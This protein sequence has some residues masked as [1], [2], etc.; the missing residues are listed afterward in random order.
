MP[1]WRCSA[2]T[3]TRPDN[4][5]RRSTALPAPP[6]AFRVDTGL[7]ESELRLWLGEP[8][9]AFDQLHALLVQTAGAAPPSWSGPL[10]IL[11]IRACADLAEQARADRNADELAAAQTHA[12][13]LSALHQQ[14]TEDPF[15]PG[16]RRLTAHADGLMWQAEWS[17]LRS[18]SDPRLWERAASAWDARTRPHR[19][20]YARWRQ[21]EALLARPGGRAAAAPELRTAAG[22]AAQH[23][24]L[25]TVIHDLA[26]RA[27]IDL[28]QPGRPAEPDQ[29]P[30]THRF[31]LTDRELA[32]LQLIAQG[33][34]NPE[35]AAALFI[36]PKTA[37]V[38][39][40]HILRKLDVTTRV[41]A[42]TIA[43]RAG[44]LTA[45]AAH[46]G[47]R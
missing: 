5:G 40:T 22:Q 4:G 12:D 1:R 27:R 29:P 19:A 6:L 43:E 16:P 18:E 42:A 46:P 32:V 8:A 2:G 10:L 11:A 37:S 45:D 14:V 21:A 31:G 13:Q 39:V 35:I 41:Q 17:R 36:S 47:V 25:S 30:A 23:V 34:T 3:W 26:R 38:H 24:P 28:S 15:T 20:A 44:L 7:R 9:A 33:K